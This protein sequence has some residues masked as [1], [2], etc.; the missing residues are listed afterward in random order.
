METN[1]LKNYL[2][3]LLEWDA[4]EIQTEGDRLLIPYVMN[5][6]VECYLQ[7]NGCKIQGQWSGEKEFTGFRLVESDERTGLILEQADETLVTVWFEEA[8][9]V[10]HCYQYH[11]IGHKWRKKPGQEQW[12]RLV[13]L[14]CV[15]H[16][17]YSFLGDAATNEQEKALLPLIEFGPLTTLSPIDDPIEEWYPET[18]EGLAAM[19][20]LARQAGDETYRAVVEGYR[21]AKGKKRERQKAALAELLQEKEHG[22]IYELLCRKLEAS[23]LIWE[24][25]D[26]GTLQNR[27]N[28]QLRRAEAGKWAA[29]GYE[30]TYPFFRRCE[31]REDKKQPEPWAAMNQNKS[32]SKERAEAGTKESEPVFPA[33]IELVEEQPFTV[34]EAEDYEFK[35]H[36]IPDFFG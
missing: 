8:R 19:E 36:A 20:S 24:P 15:L 6:A 30:G 29:L 5:D 11:R 12:R 33:C 9:L 34:L 14:L 10:T 1:T 26:Y 32:G 25:R 21:K 22:G 7:L 27:K 35:V 4:L 16:D 28:E 2:D 23:S 18:A 13:N 17:K 3:T 31:S